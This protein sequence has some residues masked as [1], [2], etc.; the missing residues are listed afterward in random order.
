MLGT[1]LQNASHATVPSAALNRSALA[2]LAVSDEMAVAAVSLPHGASCEGYFVSGAGS[3]EFNGCYHQQGAQP[4]F[5]HDAAHELYTY[6]GQWRLGLKGANLSYIAD[7]LSAWPPESSGGCGMLW[8]QSGTPE[9]GADPCPAVK[10][11]LP[12]APPVPPP[13]PPPPLP[14]VPPLP[15]MRLVWEDHFDGS[16]LDTSRWS[17]LEQ[18]HRGGVYTKGNVRVE[19]GALVLRTRAE[20]LTIDQDGKPTRFYVSSGA[21]NTSRTA[22]Q[23]FG[24]WEVRVQLPL[25]AA[26][27]GYTLHSS[28]W[29]FSD[30]ANS[31][32]SGCAQEIDVVEQYAAGGGSYKPS[33]A[34]AALHPFTGNRTAPGGCRKPTWPRPARTQ[35]VGDWTGAWTRFAVDWTD[36]W[37]AMSVDDTPYA[38]FDSASAVATF[39]DPLFLALTACVMQRIPPTRLDTLPLEYRIDYVKVYEWV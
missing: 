12:P 4:L 18:V 28:I 25:V 11:L 34:V 36:E 19:D 1:Y 33:R 3:P 5:V 15:P 10:R 22:E 16:A 32:R 38:L 17:V 37:I 13:P 23:R 24:R 30:V 20:N 6:E 9:E 8:V 2:V 29:L 39:T 26:S 35:A 7:A 27:E 21:V 31:N 14:P